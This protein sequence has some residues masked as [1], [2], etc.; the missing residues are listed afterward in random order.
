MLIDA[1][2]KE[3]VFE[4]EI[5]DQETEAGKKLKGQLQGT[6][7]HVFLSLGGKDLYDYCTLHP[8]GTNML[9]TFYRG[10]NKYSFYC[11]YDS[12]NSEMT[13]VAALT[14]IKE[15]SRRAAHRFASTMDVNLL[16]MGGGRPKHLLCSGQ[17]EDI[18]Y[19]AICFMTNHSLDEYKGRKDEVQFVLEFT[20]AERHQFKLP[21]KLLHTKM[22]PFY[23]H[24]KY[25]HVFLFDYTTCP[26]EQ[27]RL[28]D[29]FFKER[30]KSVG[31]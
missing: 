3:T 12:A 23:T 13:E 26:S 8:A 7:E 14:G 24:Y 10:S 30:L 29:I 27:G 20:M 25:A 6:H 19:D 15:E 5:M 18:S 4:I 1:I 16:E 31:G 22:A 2:E 17:A 28:V 9:L 11:R 21:G